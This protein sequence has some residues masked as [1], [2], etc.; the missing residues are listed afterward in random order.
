LS[1]IFFVHKIAFK[2]PKVGFSPLC[3]VWV[4]AHLR[5][6]K[7]VT[8]RAPMLPDVVVGWGHLVEGA[9]MAD[10]R[11]VPEPIK[12]VNDMGQVRWQ[13]QVNSGHVAAIGRAFGTLIW[14]KSFEYKPWL[15]LTKAGAKRLAR[16]WQK[17]MAKEFR[18]ER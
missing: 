12:W 7:T 16:R 1:A 15:R 3:A 9:V 6:Y 4:F 14:T 2:A 17:K 5:R 11:D 13:A 8:V 18:E 10:W